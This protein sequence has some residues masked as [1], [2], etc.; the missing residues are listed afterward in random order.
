MTAEVLTPV[1]ILVVLFGYFIETMRMGNIIKNGLPSESFFP[2]LIFLLGFPTAI[3]LLVQG[4]RASREKTAS[5]EAVAESQE[6]DEAAGYRIRSSSKPMLVTALTLVFIFLFRYLGYMI[7]A[8]LYLFFFQLI[9][10]DTLGGYR[11]KIV[12]S[13]VV[14][15]LVYALYV[16]CFNI[17]FPEVWK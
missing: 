3:Y 13:V 5:Q 10:D 12:V 17:L 7:T 1:G 6:S 15:A 16:G 8:P 9:Y 2:F 11:K 4:I 14:T